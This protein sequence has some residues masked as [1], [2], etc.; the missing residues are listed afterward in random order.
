MQVFQA[1]ES[2]ACCGSLLTPTLADLFLHVAIA[3]GAGTLLLDVV[4]ACI[5]HK[6]A[7]SA[8]M[9]ESLAFCVQHRL[10]AACVSIPSHCDRMTAVLT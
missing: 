6:V 1:L 7:L 8:P 4:R 3:S 5:R 9:Q 10:V 2:H